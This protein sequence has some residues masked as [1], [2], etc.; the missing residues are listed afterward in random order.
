[1]QGPAFDDKRMRALE[2]EW[3][4]DLRDKDEKTGENREFGLFSAGDI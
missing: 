4:K 2:D 3:L 1:M